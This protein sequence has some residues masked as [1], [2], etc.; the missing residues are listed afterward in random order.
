[1]TRNS[2]WLPELEYYEDYNIDD[3]ESDIRRNLNW[4]IDQ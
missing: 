1:M 2:C 3:R 4:F